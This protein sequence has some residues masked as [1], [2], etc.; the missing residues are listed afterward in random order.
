MAV[1]GELNPRTGFTREQFRYSLQRQNF[2]GSAT[3][4]Q[5]PQRAAC[6]LSIAELPGRPPYGR[7]ATGCRGSRNVSADRHY[8]LMRAGERRETTMDDSKH[9]GGPEMFA[10]FDMRSSEQADLQA[11]FARFW[12]HRPSNS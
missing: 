4:M 6:D 5:R 12:V 2:Q 10:N 11:H 8:P 1:P 9:I 3:A 7:N